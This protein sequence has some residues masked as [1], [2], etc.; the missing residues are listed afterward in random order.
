MFYKC[1][2][3]RLVLLADGYAVFSQ[4][5]QLLPIVPQI[6]SSIEVRGPAARDKL[7][8]PVQVVDVVCSTDEV[9]LYIYLAPYDLRK[10]G[11]SLET[12]WPLFNSDNR[13]VFQRRF[14]GWSPSSIGIEA[15]RAWYTHYKKEPLPESLISKFHEAFDEW[16]ESA[17]TQH[18]TNGHS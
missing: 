16:E 13:G 7:S 15:E 4:Y 18:E 1:H 6:G 8:H 10:E 5:D 2:F 17:S 9:D 11:E 14:P 3:N 12:L